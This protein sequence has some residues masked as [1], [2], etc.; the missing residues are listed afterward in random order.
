[1]QQYLQ[2]LLTSKSKD[3][4]AILF[5]ICKI[6]EVSNL[7]IGIY[8]CLKGVCA[9]YAHQIKPYQEKQ[10]SEKWTNSIL[11]FE[12]GSPSA[13]DKSQIALFSVS[14]VTHLPRNHLLNLMG[15]TLSRHILANAVNQ[16]AFL[17]ILPAP[18]T[19]PSHLTSL[20]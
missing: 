10:L 8:N 9:R 15:L 12:H 17:G 5:F 3:T 19:N 20:E 13:S 18:D 4:I 14:I 1:M 6:W 7:V 2:V 11:P 16:F